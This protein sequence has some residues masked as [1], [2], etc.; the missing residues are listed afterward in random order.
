MGM[1]AMN[2]PGAPG[3]GGSLKDESLDYSIV[4]PSGLSLGEAHWKAQNTGTVTSPMWSL[5]LTFEV[6][7]PGFPLID[8][9][10]S[11]SDAKFCTSHFRR[12]LEHGTKK[13]GESIDVNQQAGKATRKPMKGGGESD[14][15]VPECVHDP[16]AFLFFARDELSK[17][18]IPPNQSVL[19]GSLYEVRLTHLGTAMI[20][21]GG[22]SI[23]TDRLG[24]EI[25]GP[26]SHHN[27]EI[28]FARD[29]ARTPVLIKVP[30]PMGTFALE[31]QH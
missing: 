22:K 23:E 21:E 8:T 30:L 4:W 6:R 24:C 10:A 25:Q 1:A 9:F 26:S 7:F 19:Y 31:L 11:D 2:S 12:E 14:V 16:L 17:G 5:E 18:R 29:S 3:P 27:A 13:S 15:T 20:P 28:F